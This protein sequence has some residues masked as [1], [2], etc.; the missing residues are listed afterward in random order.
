MHAEI[1]A[2]DWSGTPLGISAAWPAALEAAFGMMLA[3]PVAMCATWGPGQTLPYNAAY[4]PFLAKRHPAALGQPLPDV[5]S[6][7][8]PDSVRRWRA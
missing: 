8:W 7:V 1:E 5:W 6:E 4:V 3:T 2:F